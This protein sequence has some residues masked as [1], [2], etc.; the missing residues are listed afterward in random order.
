MLL[1]RLGLLFGA[2]L[3]VVVAGALLVLAARSQMRLQP[4]PTDLTYAPAR[5]SASPSNR[6]SQRSSTTETG[7]EL[8]TNPASGSINPA[9]GVPDLA[10]PGYPAAPAYTDPS[11]MR[12]MPRPEVHPLP[13]APSATPLTQPVPAPPRTASAPNHP[14][15]PP[16]PASSARFRRVG[17]KTFASNPDGF[18]VDTS[19]VATA[20][21]PVV[22]VVAG[23]AE[24]AR[25]LEEHRDL[26]QFFR[27][28][29]RLIVVSDGAVYR[30]VPSR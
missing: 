28:S 15:S 19:Y 1:L 6:Q 4:P 25:V 2:F 20:N 23:S 8:D 30:V 16:E 21:L 9:T 17:D 27:L 29:D 11:Y 10:V 5:S 13:A 24:Y 18:L 14:P 12:P 26:A 22:E 7:D 3:V